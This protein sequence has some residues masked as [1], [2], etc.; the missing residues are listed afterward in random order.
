[1]YRCSSRRSPRFICPLLWLT[2]DEME[3]IVTHLSID[4]AFKFMQTCNS[5]L[6][7]VLLS[8]IRRYLNNMKCGLGALEEMIRSRFNDRVYNDSVFKSLTSGKL[9]CL[10]SATYKE[11]TEL[12]DSVATG[13]RIFIS[14]LKKQ[15]VIHL[16]APKFSWDFVDREWFILCDKLSSFTN[17]TYAAFKKHE[18]VYFKN[19]DSS[20]DSSDDLSSYESDDD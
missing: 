1:M 18:G 2:T 9:K 15:L 13:V 12:I 17:V 11:Y 19:D 7:F 5:I 10:V 3:H 14:L 4:E 6:S 16:K 8:L 20:D